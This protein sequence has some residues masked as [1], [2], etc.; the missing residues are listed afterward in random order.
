MAPSHTN[1]DC[2]GKRKAD[3]IRAVANLHEYGHVYAYGDTLEDTEMLDLADTKYL[4][5]EDVS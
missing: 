5:W 3:R 2:T 1:G 4:N